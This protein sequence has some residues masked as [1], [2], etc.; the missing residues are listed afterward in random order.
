MLIVEAMAQTAAV[1]VAR[2][3]GGERADK[4]FNFVSI[5]EGRFGRPVVPGD[6]LHLHVTCLRNRGSVWRFSGDA[7]VGGKTVAGATFVGVTDAA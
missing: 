1:L 7:K 3:L 6:T 4:L 5:K 2:T